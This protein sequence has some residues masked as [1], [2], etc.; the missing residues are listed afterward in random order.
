MISKED[1]KHLEK[2]F[3]FWFDINQND[4]TKIILSS[5]ILSLSGISKIFCND[6]SD[7]ENFS[8]VRLCKNFSNT[9]YLFLKRFNTEYGIKSISLF[10]STIKAISKIV[11]VELSEKSS[12]NSTSILFK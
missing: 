11:D 6:N 12:K 5:R 7:F 3:P 10:F 8:L 1:I 9:L 4:R 2:I